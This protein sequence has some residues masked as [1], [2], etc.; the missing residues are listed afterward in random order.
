[1]EALK[2]KKAGKAAEKKEETAE[3][4]TVPEDKRVVEDQ[5]KVDDVAVPV[6]AAEESKPAEEPVE[7]SASQA[8]T[9]THGRKPSVS[10]QSKMRSSSFRQS[11]SSPV[12]SPGSL[13]MPIFNPD[14][15]NAHEI[16][17]KQSARI[18][19]LEKEN[20][21]VLKEIGDIEKKWKKAEEELEDLRE[22]DAPEKA[23]A[24]VPTTPASSDEGIERLVSMVVCLLVV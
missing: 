17:R 5:P 18:E 10:V 3:K 24:L 13:K 8:S 23:P 14:E 16:F 21:R 7:E 9:T 1:V 20:K 15:D 22:A 12:I 19:E 2:K 4:P 11:I 6:P